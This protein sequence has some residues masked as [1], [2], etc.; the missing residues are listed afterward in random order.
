[1]SFLKK[2]I[3]WFLSMGLLCL[4]TGCTSN[5]IPLDA[6]TASFSPLTEV[7]AQAPGLRQQV[8]TTMG[9]LYVDS[10]GARLLDYVSFSANS[11]PQP[12]S[13]P[14]EQIWLS[15]ELPATLANAPQQIGSV[16]LAPVLARGRIEGSG[17]F[18]PDGAYH[19]RIVDP[20]LQIVIPQETTI[21]AL[22]QQPSDYDNRLVRVN[23]A[24]LS[25]RTSAIL[26]EE[27][28]DGG[29]PD[30][31]KYQIKLQ[32]PIEDMAM[33]TQ[34]QSLSDNAIHFGRVQIEGIWQQ[35][36]LIPLTIIPVTDESGE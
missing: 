35:K 1:M 28:G 36:R 11:I 3:L 33:L 32:S 19:Y 20:Q 21:A 27:L 23:G 12:L 17:S 8:V 30:A 24:L 4:M 5:S 13:P 10:A 14:S 16:Q 22:S 34:L 31:Q 26:S 2:R 18:G 7:I 6:T 29:V 9:Y 25:S 15:E